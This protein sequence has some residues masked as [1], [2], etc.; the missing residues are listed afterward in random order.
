MWRP[1]RKEVDRIG[2]GNLAVTNKLRYP[3]MPRLRNVIKSEESSNVEFLQ[4]ECATWS[5]L[6]RGWW[7]LWELV[8]YPHHTKGQNTGEIVGFRWYVT[9]SCGRARWLWQVLPPYP[10]Q[11]VSSA[12][13]GC[14]FR[15]HPAVRSFPRPC[16]AWMFAEP[17][18][19]EA[20]QKWF[21]C[22]PLSDE[23]ELL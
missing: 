11:S 5:V 10:V 14:A 6:F 9:R 18:A 16:I 4:E 23:M 8:G 12:E 22:W 21:H 20:A 13:F 15:Y 19:S 17:W 3:E 2:G 1:V 7:L